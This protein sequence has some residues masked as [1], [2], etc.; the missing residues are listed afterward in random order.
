MDVLR[1]PSAHSCPGDPLFRMSHLQHVS[2]LSQNNF[3]LSMAALS[4]SVAALRS[5]ASLRARLFIIQ[6]NKLGQQV[7]KTRAS[8]ASRAAGTSSVFCGRQLQ[9]PSVP[10]ARTNTF[11]GMTL[12]VFRRPRLA[13]HSDYGSR[14]IPRAYCRYGNAV[15]CNFST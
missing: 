15:L 14:Y 10:E 4:G 8:L 2:I 9:E 7:R 13:R 6:N 1:V 3:L 5:R 12:R 11:A